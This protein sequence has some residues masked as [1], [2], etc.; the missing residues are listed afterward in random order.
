MAHSPAD[1]PSLLHQLVA[2]ALPRVRRARDL[3]DA[4]LERERIVA[5]RGARLRLRFYAREVYLVIG[6]RGKVSVLVDGR[7]HRRVTV[8]GSRLYTVARFLSAGEAEVELRFSPGL[9]AYAFTFG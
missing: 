6:G 3:D 7:P 5:G 9:S 1:S 2:A 8:R 4:D